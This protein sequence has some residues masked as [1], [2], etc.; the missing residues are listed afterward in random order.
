MEIAV[1]PVP[2]SA[3]RIQ[4]Y[5]A[6]LES[7]LNFLKS[8]VNG[9]ARGGMTIRNESHRNRDTNIS[10]CRCDQLKAPVLINRIEKF[11]KDFFLNGLI[12]ISFQHVDIPHSHGNRLRMAPAKALALCEKAGVVIGENVGG[13]EE[14]RDLQNSLPNYKITVFG[15]RRG[16]EVIFEGRSFT[17]RVEERKTNNL[18]HGAVHFNL[19]TSLTGAFGCN[20]YSR[21]CRFPYDHHCAHKCAQKWPHAYV[22]YDIECRQDD[23][24]ISTS[25]PTMLVHMPNLLVSNTC[26]ISKNIDT[27]DFCGIRGHIFSSDDPVRDFILHI[28]FLGENNRQVTC[29]AHTSKGYDGNFIIKSISENTL[30][31]PDII[32]NGSKILSITYMGLPFIDS[33]NFLLM[34]LSKL[35]KCLG[36]QA[37]IV[38]GNFPH[39]F[40]TKENTKYVGPIPAPEAYGI[41]SMSMEE[42][43]ISSVGME[44]FPAMGMSSPWRRKFEA[45]ASRTF[46]FS[47]WHVYVSCLHEGISPQLPKTRNARHYP[48]WGYRLAERQSRKALLWLTWEEK[49]WGITIRHAGNS[50]EVRILGW[51]MDGVY[52]GTVFEFHGCYFH[53]C[54]SC[55]P[56]RNERIPNSPMKPWEQDMRRRR[57]KSRNS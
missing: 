35:P 29:I 52:E 32:M 44:N 39:F 26:C 14:I 47:T 50:R 51:K 55:F 4:W 45:I 3:N 23:E 16:K 57:R 5:G 13:V 36:L 46:P 34:P 6:I 15:D 42:K 48:P 25:S 30:W 49:G 31:K 37:S 21:Y 38:K 41:D 24:F 54:P 27:C 11:N 9:S 2:E 1:R 53:G 17:S 56:N 12:Y 20:Y 33:L 22:F 8:G 18:I 19:I 28:E 43:G 10:F 7:L 40:N